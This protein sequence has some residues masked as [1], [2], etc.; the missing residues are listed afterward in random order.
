[1]PQLIS[2][3]KVTQFLFEALFRALSLKPDPVQAIKTFY[4]FRMDQKWIDTALGPLAGE[5]AISCKEQMLLVHRLL[6]TLGTQKKSAQFK[7]QNYRSVLITA[8]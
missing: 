3:C 7:V 1:M 4:G 2:G 8:V 5:K 6:H